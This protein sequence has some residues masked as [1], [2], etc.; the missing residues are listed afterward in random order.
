MSIQSGLGRG[1]DALLPGSDNDSAEDAPYFL[2]PVESINPNPYQP[3]KDFD[4][5]SLEE[6]ADS[7]REKGVIQPLIVHKEDENK[8]GFFLIAGERRW[9]AS[10]LA[11]L[12]EVPV[13]VKDV[14]LG[15]QLE[16]ALIENIQRQ[17]LNPIDEAEAYSR[18]INDFGFTQEETAR[19]VGKMRTTVA[20]MLRLL[21]LPD[22]I[23]NDIVANKL[24]VGHARC[25][26]SVIDDAEAL[27]R[28]RK[29]IV[30]KNLS[31][32]QTEELI[33]SHKK[34]GSGKNRPP[35]RKTGSI[36]KPYSRALANA[37]HSYLGS[38]ARIVQNGT[39]G[40]IEVTYASPQDLERILG[41]IIKDQE[42]P[43][44][45]QNPQKTP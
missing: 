27:Q 12:T 29:E 43:L 23:K 41:L 21:K 2:C 8:D 20:N 11:G 42:K 39:Q 15:E 33:K 25:L 5:A 4:Q 32:R 10:Q 45:G 17:D 34:T 44:A 40:K 3:R 35:K 18:L 16:L 36:A 22:S 28:L 24:T 37:L 19:R 38:P 14:S 1:L 6:L 9:R 30:S 26:L 31:V 13:L 7:I